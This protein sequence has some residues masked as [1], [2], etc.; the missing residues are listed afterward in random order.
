MSFESRSFCP[1]TCCW[2]DSSILICSDSFSSSAGI[3]ENGSTPEHRSL[4]RCRMFSYTSLFAAS[5]ALASLRLLANLPPIFETLDSRL[6]ISIRTASISVCFWASLSCSLS[7]LL[8]HS[9]FSALC[10]S[11]SCWSC[12]LS[13]ARFRIRF[14]C[15]SV[16]SCSTISMPRSELNDSL[17]VASSVPSFA[18]PTIFS[19]S[20]KN[21][22]M[23]PLGIR[24]SINDCQCDFSIVSN[25]PN[26]F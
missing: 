24:S 14:T 6:S 16:R 26:S 7:M 9:S 15:R 11:K 1:A 5:F 4:I 23:M 22:R 13:L 3:S 8:A 17:M 19:P 25:G 10:F 18:I 2:T 20:K 21:S 12:P